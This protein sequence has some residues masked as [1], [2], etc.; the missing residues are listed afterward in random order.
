MPLVP[1]L[2]RRLIAG[3][4][5]QILVFAGVALGFASVPQ[6]SSGS[7][8]IAGLAVSLCE[9]GK[10]DDGRQKSQHDCQMCALGAA[11][12][13]PVPAG[14]ILPALR[15]RPAGTVAPVDAGTLVSSSDR[16]PPPRGPPVV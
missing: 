7:V 13:L 6:A 14:V 11:P 3:L 5:I 9:T 8:V 2:V 1:T 10:A 12:L 15:T 16:R 4:L